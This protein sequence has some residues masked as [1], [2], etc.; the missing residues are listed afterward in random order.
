MGFPSTPILDTFTGSDGT[1]LTVYSANWTLITANDLEI[2]GNAATGTAVATCGVMWNVADYGPSSEVYVTLSTTPADGQSVRIFL[3]YD[4]VGDTGYRLRQNKVAG[5]ANDTW[6][7]QRDDA[8]AFTTLGATIT[9]EVSNGD[10]IGIF[11][12]GSIIAAYYK[13]V[14]GSWTEL[15]TRE[16]AT[17]TAAAKLMLFCTDTTVRLDDFGGGTT[18]AN[19]WYAYAQQ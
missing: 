9:Q 14:A 13:A 8:D 11:M 1:D 3:R 16:D 4:L 2:Q 5:A 19:P 6:L 15:G 10:A 7:L 12:I 18:V 17:Y